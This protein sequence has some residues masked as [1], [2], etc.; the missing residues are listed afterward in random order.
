MNKIFLITLLFFVG[1]YFCSRPAALE[2][3]GNT[4]ND[5]P[6]L[7]IQKGKELFL[8]NKNKQKR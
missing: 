7:L 4:E 1:L 2:G 8:I 5:C 6:N 3:F